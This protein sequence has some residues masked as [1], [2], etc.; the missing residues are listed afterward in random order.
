MEFEIKRIGPKIKGSW[1]AVD[2]GF[3]E[4]GVGPNFEGVWQGWKTKRVLS[5][6]FDVEE[7]FECWWEDEEELK[8]GNWDLLKVTWRET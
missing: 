6:L 2:N 5:Q 3:G 8:N 7:E 4:T 1:L